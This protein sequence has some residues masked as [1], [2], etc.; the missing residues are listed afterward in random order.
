MHEKAQT[1]LSK[2]KNYVKKL[3]PR[4]QPKSILKNGRPDK[5]KAQQYF[6]QKDFENDVGVGQHGH[7]SYQASCVK[8]RRVVISIIACHRL[9]KLVTRKTAV[10]LD[11]AE[12]HRV[13]ATVTSDRAGQPLSTE[14]ANTI[15]LRLVSSTLSPRGPKD[16]DLSIFNCN[17][18]ESLTSLL[19]V[20]LS[21]IKSELA[22]SQGKQSLG[23]DPASTAPESV[24]RLFEGASTVIKRCALLV[25]SNMSL[26]EEELSV[27]KE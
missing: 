15:F 8:L 6:S 23:Q 2:T 25:K 27:A 3:L 4:H 14:M 22:R 12:L 7:L 18:F 10:C 5:K 20:G 1:E 16:Q 11:E 9:K 24:R 19:R 13:I 21:N 17:R 26:R